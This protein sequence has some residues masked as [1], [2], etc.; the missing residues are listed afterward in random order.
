MSLGPVRSI[1]GAGSAMSGYVPYEER[2]RRERGQAAAIA[3][4]A[5]MARTGALE[6]T[7]SLL[8]RLGGSGTDC[9]LEIL[10][11]LRG[12]LRRFFNE[13]AIVQRPGLFGGPEFVIEEVL[14]AYRIEGAIVPPPT[15]E[16]DADAFDAYAVPDGRVWRFRG[17]GVAPGTY[18]LLASSAEDLSSMSTDD[19]TRIATGLLKRLP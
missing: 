17:Q 14:P 5:A 9:Y 15:K 11:P 4:A 19:L 3:A 6:R 1:F 2:L 10:T 16:G 7:G 12:R 8:D 13:K 18:Q